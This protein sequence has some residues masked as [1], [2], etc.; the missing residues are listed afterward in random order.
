MKTRVLLYLPS[1]ASEKIAL[2]RERV[3][4]KGGEDRRCKQRQ[5]LR[6]GDD[7]DLLDA[8]FPSSRLRLFRNSLLCLPLVSRR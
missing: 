1:E 8:L 3:V 6:C 2:S 7:V 4:E 5:R